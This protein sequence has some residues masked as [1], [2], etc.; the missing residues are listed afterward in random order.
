MDLNGQE[1]SQIENV[2]VYNFSNTLQLHLKINVSLRCWQDISR[3][4]KC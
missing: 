3:K 1:V 4:Q 2:G